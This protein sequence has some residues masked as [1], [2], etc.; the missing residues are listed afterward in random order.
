MRFDHDGE[1]GSKAV[2]RLEMHR[3]PGHMHQ[4]SQ[5]MLAVEIA[6]AGFDLMLVLA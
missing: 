6:R 4:A 3:M 1:P 2:T 5:A